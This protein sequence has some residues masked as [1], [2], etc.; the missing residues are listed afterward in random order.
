MIRQL[1]IQNFKA[2]RDVTIELTPLHLFIGPND[3][4]KTSILQ[5]VTALSR[6]VDVQLSKAFV[7][8]WQDSQLVWQG[9]SDLNVRLAARIR[10]D[11]LN[12]GYE[13]V[14]R[15][16]R[17]RALCR[18]ER[19]EIGS[20]LLESTAQSRYTQVQVLVSGSET[21]ATAITEQAAHVVHT[22]LAGCQSYRWVP[23]FLALPVAANARR[24]FRMEYTG[25]GLATCLDDILGTDRRQFDE[26]ER[27]FR[28]LFPQVASIQLRLEPAF[29]SPSDDP[30]QVLKLTE[31]DGKAIYFELA[32]PLCTVPASQVSDGMLLVLALLAILHLPQPPR[33]LLVEEPES[34]VHPELLREVVRMLRKLVKERQETQILLTSH[35][36]YL[37]SLFK[38]QEVSLCRKED[39]GSVSVHRLSESKTV[40]EQID[41]FTL[42]EIWTAEGDEALASS[43]ADL[44]VTKE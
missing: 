31:A 27:Q 33:F 3:S 26:L 23:G 20:E 9:R 39:D 38:P 41:I 6:S 10:A 14:S 17:G 18:S 7:G 40:R 1:Q 35:S 19:I 43:T 5:A 11:H 4:G 13:L 29:T 34:G 16:R 22:S 44:E 30:T 36:P 12:V 32:Q 2:L 25:F 42:G 28:R 8:R 24:R 15:F 21:P 37:V